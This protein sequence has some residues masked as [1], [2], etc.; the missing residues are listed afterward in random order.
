[1]RVPPEIKRL[2]RRARMRAAAAVRRPFARALNA[3]GA[4]FCPICESRVRRFGP[5]GRPPRANA[6]CPVCRSLE[7]HRLDWLFMARRTDLLDGA[8]R[9]MLH[10]APEEFLSARFRRLA[11]LDYLSADLGRPRAMVRMDITNIDRPD[12]TF[13]VI[14]CSHVLEHI[15][16][17]RKALAELFRVLR[18]GGWALLQVPVTAA[19]TE[20]DPGVVDPEERRRRYGQ[21]DHVRRCGP[22]YAGRMTAAGFEVDVLRCADVATEAEGERMGLP[23]DGIVFFCR[24]APAKGGGRS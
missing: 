3:S 15:A 4:R 10:V 2:A 17:D 23:R 16:D 18:P 6:R 7:R 19:R 12:A 24:K 11:G 14:Y 8:P 9:A 21:P 1:M 13:D 20:E 22:D 5:S